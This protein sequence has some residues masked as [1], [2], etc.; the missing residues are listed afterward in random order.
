L[1]DPDAEKFAGI[2][3]HR[4]VQQLRR[5]VDDFMSIEEELLREDEA[6]REE[7]LYHRMLAVVHQLCAA[8]LACENAEMDPEEIR[9]VLDPVRRVHARSPFVE[10][11][12]TWPRGYPGD[13]ETVEYLIGGA[14]A[15]KASD[16]VA[17]SCEAYALSRRLPS[18][19]AT[20]S[21]ISRRG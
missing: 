3:Q 20:R 15:N 1:S 4:A 8:I 10:R 17:R 21:S 9:A 19:I 7:E 6:L 5:H 14:G 13:F 11:L 12:Q 2:Q 16:R 18:S